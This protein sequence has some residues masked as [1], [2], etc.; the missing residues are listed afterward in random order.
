MPVFAY[1]GRD[2]AGDAVKGSVERVSADLVAEHL[3]AQGIVPVEIWQTRQRST[4][5]NFNK[6]LFVR[7][8]SRDLIATFARQMYT[9]Y[10]AGV[11]LSTSLLRIAQTAHHPWLVHAL[12]QASKDIEDGNSLA[13]ALKQ[14]PQVFSELFTNLIYV[15]ET[16]GHLEQTFLQL[17]NYFELEDTTFKQ[18]KA[19][20]RYP[21]IV[22]VGIIGAMIVVMVVMIPAFAKLFDNYQAKLPL[23]TRV[24]MGLS[25]VICQ[26]GWWLSIVVVVAVAAVMRYMRTPRG[27]YRWHKL[28]LRFPVIGPLINKILF[29]RFARSFAMVI[30][31]N[32]PIHRGLE[33]VA[34][35]LGN[36]YLKQE[37]MTMRQELARGESL[38]VVA[39][40][41]GIFP[42]L[43][44]Q[45]LTVGEE[46]GT[47]DDMLEQIGEFYE[48]EVVFGLKRLSDAMEP[49]L[50]MCI[51]VMVLILALGVFMPMWSMSRL[52]QVGT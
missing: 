24:L 21:L 40:R 14:H 33:L 1:R 2:R 18:L 43:V 35:A 27:R 26:Q 42:L 5:F 31:T 28:Q 7:P 30:R 36:D 13:T 45:M 12:M 10:K 3:F 11:P 47:L 50:L 23:A 52:V 9:L 49:L 16:A 15:G 32:I 39:K 41:S 38:S 17:A 29:A 51:G 19:V 44:L 20:L 48:R 6:N 22:T 8:P 34:G 46:A 25:D 37:L 4:W